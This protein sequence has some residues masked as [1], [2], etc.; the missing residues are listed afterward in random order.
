[1]WPFSA[2]LQEMQAIALQTQ[3][4]RGEEEGIN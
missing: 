2:L 4:A 3:A 1:M